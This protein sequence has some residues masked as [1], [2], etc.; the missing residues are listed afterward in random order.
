MTIS[1]PNSLKSM[2]TNFGSFGGQI[3]T[4][5][6]KVIPSSEKICSVVQKGR[7]RSKNYR[8]FSQIFPSKSVYKLSTREQAGFQKKKKKNYSATGFNFTLNQLLGSTC[9]PNQTWAYHSPSGKRELLRVEITPS[10]K[11]CWEKKRLST[12]FRLISSCYSLKISPSPLGKHFCGSPLRNLV[13]PS[14]AHFFL[15]PLNI[16]FRHLSRKFVPDTLH[17]RRVSKPTTETSSE[18]PL[19]PESTSPFSRDPKWPLLGGSLLHATLKTG[20]RFAWN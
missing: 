20:H 17:M 10:S 11:N 12:S 15:F 7:K 14:C 5:P 19:L 2:G 9:Y 3:Q 6:Q 1:K 8:W 4:V 16:I 18:V 13:R